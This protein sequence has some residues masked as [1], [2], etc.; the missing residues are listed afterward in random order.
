MF[1]T[2]IRS[3]YLVS[4]NTGEDVWFKPGK[5]Y[6]KTIIEEFCL[7]TTCY[8]FTLDEKVEYLCTCWIKI[9]DPSD[10]HEVIKSLLLAKTGGE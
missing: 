4:Q 6:C 5:I 8:G 9:V 2:P 10:I 1:F 3:F 7:Y